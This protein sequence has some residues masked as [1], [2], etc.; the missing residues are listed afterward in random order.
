MA[1]LPAVGPQPPALV[2][3]VDGEPPLPLRF[4]VERGALAKAGRASEWVGRVSICSC[5]IAGCYSQY[6]WFRDGECI[7]LFTIGGAC[8]VS[9]DWR[10]FRLGP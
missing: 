10:P 2:V 5:G 1:T 8:L 4:E 7:A 6:G 3:P 9:V